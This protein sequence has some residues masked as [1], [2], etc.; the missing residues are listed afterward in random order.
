MY[1][2]F[3]TNKSDN[4]SGNGWILV[5]V[6]AMTWGFDIV[7]RSPLTAAG[8]DASLIVFGEHL[9]LTLVF[10]PI[11]IGSR[12]QFAA[13]SVQNWL[14]LLF[15]AWGASAVATWLYT[16]AFVYGAPLSAVLLQKTQPLFALALAPTMLGEKRRRL[17]WPLAAAALVGAYLLALGWISPLAA[18]H[19]AGIKA[20]A[21]AI[22][23][24]ALWGAGTVAGRKLSQALSPLTIAAGRFTLAMPLLGL[25]VAVD[26]KS[27]ESISRLTP[28]L[29]VDWAAVAAVPGLLGMSLYYIGMRT[30][31]AS[32]ATLA[33]LAYPATA[34][35]TGLFLLHQKMDIAQTAGLVIL[36]IAVHQI[37]VS[38]AV[39]T[40]VEGGIA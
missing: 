10:L 37:A 38:H 1:N 16:L 19:G 26:P 4:V 14:A 15:V 39:E 6:A 31:P 2:H 8:L 9:M 30:T 11:L 25:T 33:E 13:L 24:S 22:A 3:V 32:I 5:T 17:F 18:M 20:G 35:L 7:F 36:V 27:A 34:L 40:T 28:V 12:K 29:A 23:A 21:C